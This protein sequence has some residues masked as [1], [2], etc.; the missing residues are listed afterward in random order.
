M[1]EL[2]SREILEAEISNPTSSTLVWYSASWCNP[3]R[4]I[5]ATAVQ[6]AAS[7]A[8]I[9]FAH[10]DV[11]KVPMAVHLHSISRIPTFV[12]F[13]EGNELARLNSA[14]TDEIIAWITRNAR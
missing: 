3:C 6:N 11:D 4:R 2:T 8:R 13:R 14:N 10:C 5:D 7:V 12:L 1:K 9:T